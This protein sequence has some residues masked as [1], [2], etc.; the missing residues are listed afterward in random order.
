MEVA[1]AEIFSHTFDRSKGW[2]RRQKTA[3]HWEKFAA[4]RVGW[5]WLASRLLGLEAT[6]A[7]RWSQ[8]K[9]TKRKQERQR[10][11]SDPKKQELTP[12]QLA[13]IAGGK[14]S[15]SSS[16]SPRVPGSSSTTPHRPPV[17]HVYS[18]SSSAPK[19]GSSSSSSSR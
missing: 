1:G 6:P 13:K 8:I 7:E 4:A 3:G 9:K 2:N 15:S 19:S 12:E 18:S 16:S 11:M 5:A 10:L 14:G 17:H